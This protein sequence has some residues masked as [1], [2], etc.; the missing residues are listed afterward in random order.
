M[1]TPKDEK[2]IET[3]LHRTMKNGYR[4]QQRKYNIIAF[5]LLLI[6]GLAMVTLDSKH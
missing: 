5:V 3:I 1:K 4:V 2:E 6:L